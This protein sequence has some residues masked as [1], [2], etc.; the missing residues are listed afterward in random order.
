MVSTMFGHSRGKLRRKLLN[1]CQPFC[2]NKNMLNIIQKLQ[3]GRQVP[4]GKKSGGSKEG[5]HGSQGK[6]FKY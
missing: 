3:E 5:K 2:R 6:S 4:G 1:A